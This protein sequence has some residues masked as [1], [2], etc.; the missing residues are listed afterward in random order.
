M[1]KVFFILAV[2]SLLLF[3]FSPAH[4]NPF[5]NGKIQ[6]KSE[7]GT[8]VYRTFLLKITLMQKDLRQKM[9]GLISDFRNGKSTLPLF[10]ALLV[11]FCYGVLHAAGPGHGKAFATAYMLSERPKAAR[12]VAMGSFIGFFHGISGALSVL[13]L[14]FMLKQTVSGSLAR[15]EHIA[16]ITSYSL[17]SILGAVLV[18]KSL[19]Q[20]L[21]GKE[22]SG[23]HLSKNF[24][25]WG[26]FRRHDPLSRCCHDNAFLPLFRPAV[27]GVCFVPFCFGRYGADHI[28]CGC[29]GLHGQ[30]SVLYV[31]VR[32]KNSN[33]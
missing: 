13:L 14:D 18:I 4:A 12:G 5:T 1:N 24:F 9:A 28:F 25:L 15:T 7:S 26:G 19:V 11:S 33:M 6:Q 20:M 2:S 29:R 22:K 31:S 8:N 3:S 21:P 10:Y 27:S 23:R 17:L 30:K 16:R 32:R